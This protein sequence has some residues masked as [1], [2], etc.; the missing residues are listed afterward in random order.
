MLRRSIVAGVVVALKFTLGYSMPALFAL[1]LLWESH[2]SNDWS[3]FDPLSRWSA[4][5]MFYGVYLVIA[6]VTAACFRRFPSKYIVLAGLLSGVPLFIYPS[7]TASLFPGSG[8]VVGTVL[9]V[10]ACVALATWRGLGDDPRMREAAN[11]DA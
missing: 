2:K 6:L 3:G 5:P 4:I 11:L 10:A 1:A 8:P 7:Q 9:G